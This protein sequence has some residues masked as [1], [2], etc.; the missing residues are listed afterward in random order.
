MIADGLSLRWTALRKTAFLAFA[1]FVG[2]SAAWGQAQ[3][4]PTQPPPAQAAPVQAAPAPAAPA[5]NAAPPGA[6]AP[7]SPEQAPQAQQAPPVQAPAAV[8]GAAPQQPAAPAAGE[9]APPAEPAP[10]P[11]P[12]LTP[13]EQREIEEAVRPIAKI[14]SDLERLEKAVEHSKEDDE[15]LARLRGDL[16]EVFRSAAATRD[17]LQPKSEAIAQQIEKL[18]P[19]PEK[20]ATESSEVAAERT[21]LKTMA[22]EF[23]GALKNTELLFVRARQLR[24]TLQTARQELF[25]NQLFRRTLSPVAPTIWTR[26]ISDAPAAGRQITDTFSTWMSLAQRKWTDVAGLLL[27]VVLLFVLLRGLAHRILAWRLDRPRDE[28]PS[29]FV[30]AATAGWVAPLLALPALTALQVL[31]MG[32]DQFKLLT[33]EIGQIAEKVYP[34]LNVFIGVA[35]LARAILQP[36]RPAWR[37]VDLS[38]PAARTLTRI[39]TLIAAVF[40]ADIILQEMVRRLFLPFSV[41]IME[42]A[43][44]SIAIGI[45]MLKLVRTPFQPGA[46]TPVQGQNVHEEGIAGNIARSRL[47]PYLIKLPLLVA[48]LIIL[49]ASLLGYVGLGRFVTQQ[50]ILTG[51]AIA[52]FLIFHLAIRALF[53]APGSGVKPFDDVLQ[54]RL[55]LEAGQSGLLSRTLY[56]MLNAA[57]A[58]SAVPVILIIWGYSSQEALYWMRQAVFGF[59][60]GEF[61]ISLARILLAAGLF[62]LLVF[63]TR[64]VQRWIDRGISHSKRMD[65][66]I[67]NSIHTA[68][69]YTGFIVATLAAISYGGLDITNIAI[70]AGALSV[71]IGF[72]LQSIINNFVSG[73]ILLVERPIKVG[74]RVT[75]NGQD[76]FVRRISVRSTE[77]E[78]FDRASLIVPNS[79][80]ITTTLTNWTH[81]NALGRAL[82]KVTVAHSSD[83][84]LVHQTLLKVAE[85]CPLVQKHPPA[86]SGLD[87]FAA[88]GLEFILI[89]VVSDIGKL[90]DARSDLRMRIVKAFREAGIEISHP[91]RDVRVRDL[92]AVHTLLAR[93]AEERA[94]T[95]G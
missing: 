57:L 93:M 92:D 1:A 74:D 66:G 3:P 29:F 12:V 48:A 77:I 23:D 41:N 45:L 9:T 24:V 15:A 42:A 30:R 68:V 50:V 18:G 69:G 19:P 39:I 28:P 27:A 16:I 76:G 53:G 14:K 61:R 40:A 52:V 82:I 89:A 95:G 36:R 60:I 2:S 72:G 70:V 5:Q 90:G 58:L 20:D 73:L 54:E 59:Q 51:S 91:R 56:V 44:A 64:I 6:Q 47:R 38:T 88:D 78:T 7:Q 86:W 84:E 55:G 13:A 87:N 17:A 71:G 67:A 22:S 65:Q 31:G 32:L 94:R 43:L 37:L 11:P 75:V 63:V 4:Q 33:W 81:R 35:A 49:G 62:L 10:P 80:F 83:P 46:L 26:L 34:A 85:D 79:E 8:N 21:R 25:A